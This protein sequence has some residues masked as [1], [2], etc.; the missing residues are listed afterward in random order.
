MV[1]CRHHARGDKETGTDSR[2]LPGH[3]TQG[4]RPP[5]RFHEE[6]SYLGGPCD[7]YSRPGLDHEEIERIPTPGPGAASSRAG[8]RGT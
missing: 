5:I 2:R 4:D 3:P 7:V 6:V 1:F 8:T